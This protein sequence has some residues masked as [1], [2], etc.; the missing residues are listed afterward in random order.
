MATKR[1]KYV[2]VGGGLAGTS[3]ASGIRERDAQGSILLIGREEE[4]PYDRPPL[5]KQLWFGR[6]KV[7]DIFLHD[8][9]Y[10]AQTGIELRL[11]TTIWTLDPRHKLVQDGT[12][13]S[14]QFEKLLLATGGEPRRLSIPGGDLPGIVYYR[15]LADYRRLREAATQ[16]TSA[17][18]I[19]G[20]FIG[21][22]IAAGLQAN[23][24]KVTLLFPDPYLCARI[25][26]APLAQAIQTDYARRGVEILAEDQPVEIVHD[27]GKYTVRTRGGRNLTSDLVIAGIGIAPELK[28]ATAAGLETGNGIMVNEYLQTSEPD[29]YAAGDNAFFHY[30]ALEQR[31]RVE[32]WDNA[33]NQ[34]KC[35]GRNMAGAREPYSYMPFFFSDLFEFGYEAVGE[36]DARLP[37]FADWQ[38]ENHTGVIYYLRDGRVAGV[39]LC[40]VWEKVERA[41]EMIRGREQ[42]TRDSLRGAIR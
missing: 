29:I 40:N 2:I 27:N 36:L 16:G 39:M 22:E 24:V 41:R 1:Y 32:H 25:F 30:V 19:G 15:T 33:L 37:T 7:D 5:T 23:G 12:G 38:K 6:K 31:T 35:A 28:L 8:R 11:A 10:Y 21:S 26:P 4:L 20:G 9:K 42:W 18:V 34:G 17:L 14:Y 13:D 3:A